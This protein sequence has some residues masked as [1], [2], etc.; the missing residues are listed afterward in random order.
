MW[1][2]AF[3]A[4]LSCLIFAGT[5]LT[6]S[7]QA[8]ISFSRAQDALLN[9]Q[10]Y[11]GGWTHFVGGGLAVFDCNQDQLPDFY[12]AGGSLPSRLYRNESKI[13]GPLRFSIVADLPQLTEVIGAYPIDINNDGAMDLVV[14]RNGANVILQGHGQCKFTKAPASWGF[15][16][17][18]EW[19]TAFSPTF[20][21]GQVWPTLAFGN[22]VDEKN[23]DG[24]FETCDRNYLIRPEGEKFT[25]R[26]AL[27]PGF[28]ALSMLFSDWRRNGE[29]DL[30]ISNDRQ[31]YV[32]KG[33]EQMWRL[34][35]LREFGEADQWPEI[36]IWGMGIASRD[37]TNDGLPDVVLTSMGDQLLQI[38]QGNGTY[39]PAP[40]EKGTYATTPYVG[41]DGRP[42]TGWHAE[43]GDVNNDGFDDLFIAKG[44]VDQMPS[45]AIHDPNNLLIQQADGH[46]VEMGAKTGLGTLER[47]RG[48]SLVDLNRDGLLDI[49]VINRRA[50]MEIWQNTSEKT[51][52]WLLLDLRQ[53]D[54]NRNAIGAIAEVKLPDG[55]ILT[56]ENTIGGGHVSGKLTGLHFGLGQA[57][58]VEVR[59]TWPHG[60]ASEWQPIQPDQEWIIEADA[61]QTL[62]FKVK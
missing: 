33:R 22:Y 52:H 57:S 41:D 62:R 53:N 38:N 35:P 19:T 11:G 47:S 24:P 45:N 61:N 17:G 4:L 27:E 43:F 7:A 21:K 36:K 34:N 39:K 55:R 18:D 3:F 25:P 44:N 46:F 60:E 37:I 48:A 12:A 56:Q 20:E 50:N 49:L 16:A 26:I 42:S 40:Y 29:V 13:S 9:E 32:R 2:S 58:Q 51:G 14:L 1:R 15:A 54:H 23:P 28:C 31:Y 6:R 8:E 10:I 59:V 30:R 5:A